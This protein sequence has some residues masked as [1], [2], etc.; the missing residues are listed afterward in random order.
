MPGGDGVVRKLRD[1]LLNRRLGIETNFHGVQRTNARLKMPPGSRATSL[2]SS[3]SS[4]VIEILV[5]LAIWR[6]DTPFRS[7]AARSLGRNHS[8]GRRPSTKEPRLC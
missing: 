7:R 8:P 5:L 4:T 1:E 2:R 3:A 6:S